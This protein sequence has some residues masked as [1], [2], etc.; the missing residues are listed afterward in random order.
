MIVEHGENWRFLLHHGDAIPG[1]GVSKGNLV[2]L[3]RRVHSFSQMA[4][5]S[6][7]YSLSGHFHRSSSISLA[8]GGRIIGNGS[9]PGGSPFSVA[10]LGDCQIPSQKL[11]LFSPKRGVH[12]ET[13][14]ILGERVTLKADSNRVLTNNYRED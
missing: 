12:S 7:H 6:I 5:C 11:L 13:D 1:G 14:I 9:F 3:E 10:V 2:S 4:D 8:G